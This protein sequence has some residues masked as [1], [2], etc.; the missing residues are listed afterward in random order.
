[1]LPNIITGYPTHIEDIFPALIGII[2]IAICLG[3][4]RK[5]DANLIQQPNSYG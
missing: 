1:M 4:V 2:R 3:R 5:Y